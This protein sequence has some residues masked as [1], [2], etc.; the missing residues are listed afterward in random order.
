[1]WSTITQISSKRKPFTLPGSACAGWIYLI[2]LGGLLCDSAEVRTS[3]ALHL[4]L[5][6]APLKLLGLRCACKSLSAHKM[7]TVV[8]A[9]KLA[10]CSMLPLSGLEALSAQ[11][12]GVL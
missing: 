1:M 3:Y 6:T 11:G 9:R 12:F 10:A 8:K 4:W 7:P 2:I 5:M